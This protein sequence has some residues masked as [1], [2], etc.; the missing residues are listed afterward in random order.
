MDVK[1]SLKN[2]TWISKDGDLDLAQFPIDGTLKQALSGDMHKFR[3]GLNLLQGMYGSGRDEAGIFLLGLLVAC[4][5]DL[6]RRGLIVEALEGVNTKA[7]ADLLF[8]ELQRV[9]SSNTTRRYLATVIKVLTS[10]PVELIQDGFRVLA[11]DK[12]FSPKMRAKFEEARGG[13]RNFEEDWF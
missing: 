6:E 2:V 5:D 13:N 10:M 7:C 4:N 11:D 1:K 9:K 3:S 8:A 12:S